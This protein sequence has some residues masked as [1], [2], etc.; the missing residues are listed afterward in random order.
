MKD[1]DN[2][3]KLVGDMQKEA[4]HTGADLPMKDVKK[5]FKK[6]NQLG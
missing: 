3:H 2:C 4:N 1:L 6:S 5:D